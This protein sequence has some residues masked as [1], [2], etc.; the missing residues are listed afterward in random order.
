MKVTNITTV[1]KNKF[2]QK[3]LGNKGVINMNKSQ[4]TNVNKGDTLT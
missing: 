1:T 2:P 3:V 4:S